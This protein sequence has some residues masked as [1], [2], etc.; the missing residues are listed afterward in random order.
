[1]SHTYGSMTGMMHNSPKQKMFKV[2][3]MI[4]AIISNLHFIACSNNNLTAAREAYFKELGH[5][6]A[7][8]VTMPIVYKLPLMQIDQQIKTLNK[9]LLA[10]NVENNNTLFPS[11]SALQDTLHRLMDFET[12]MI[13]DFIQETPKLRKRSVMDGVNSVRDFF[14]DVLIT[15]CRVLTYRD[16]KNILN[17]Q[18]SIATS[19]ETLRQTVIEDHQ[20]LIQINEKGD[21]LVRH[22]DTLNRKL[23]GKFMEI[24]RY[25]KSTFVDLNLEQVIHTQDF[26]NLGQSYFNSLLLE[27]LKFRHMLDSC[28]DFRL[29][30]NMVDKNTLKRD[31]LKMEQHAKKINM[32]LVIPIT[33]L[34]SY[35]HSALINC[36]IDNNFLEIDVKI[37]LQDSMK[38]YKIFEITTLP[39]FSNNKICRILTDDRILIADKTNSY[40]KTLSQKDTPYCDTSK[41]LCRIPN[42]RA[43]SKFDDCITAIFRQETQAEIIHKCNF[44]CQT[45]LEDE[46][47]TTQLEENIFSITN[48]DTIIAIDMMSQ[49]RETVKFD[50]KMHGTYIIFVP[51]HTEIMN[52]NKKGISEVVIPT[53]IPCIQDM[54][55][56]FTVNK[57]LPFSWINLTATNISTFEEYKTNNLNLTKFNPEWN[58]S[59]F[60][61]NEIEP[62]E[63]LTKRLNNLEITIPELGYQETF[64]LIHLIIIMWLSLIT[65]LL[66]LILYCTIIQ[67]PLMLPSEIGATGLGALA[68]NLASSIEREIR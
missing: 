13:N 2:T 16:G 63:N 67:K 57:I 50:E 1:M 19:Y 34:N 41:H 33:D 28:K 40:V 8:E 21:N 12:D 66:A 31:L 51:C 56:Q 44:Y 6:R 26:L 58:M 11:I 30:A 18:K 15:C 42:G 54:K 38:E 62:T 53:G 23:E 55:T 52:I 25:L 24:D 14:G 9:K 29:S 48:F 59:H 3:F 7:Y 10:L 68:Q 43:N 61:S 5:V 65:I 17:N 64:S 45:R 4:I 35:Y 37:P 46:V 60:I 32:K 47:I 36:H 39:F 49:K 22:I 27:T 20:N